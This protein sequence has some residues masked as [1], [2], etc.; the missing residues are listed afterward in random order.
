MQRGG[1]FWKNIFFEIR[2]KK[3]CGEAHILVFARLCIDSTSSAF[4]HAL[5]SVPVFQIH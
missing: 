3:K 5:L 1:V 4:I 2:R